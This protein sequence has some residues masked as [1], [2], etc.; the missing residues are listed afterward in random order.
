MPAQ[1]LN[2]KHF[3]QQKL[4]ELRHLVD[5]FSKHFHRRPSLA[6]IVIGDLTASMLYI[7]YKIAACHVLG[8]KSFKFVFAKDVSEAEIIDKIIELNNLNEVDGILV[9]LPLPAHINSALVMQTIAP[10]KDVDGFHPLNMGYLA[11]NLPGLR[12]CT[13]K[14]II[15]L[16]EQTGENLIDKHAVILGS[17]LIVGRPMALELIARRATVTICNSKTQKIQEQVAQADILIVAIGQYEY[18]QGNWCKPG[19]III[20]V[21]INKNA[22]GQLAG[23]VHFASASAIASWIT[24]VPGGVG[25]MTVASLMENTVLAYKINNGL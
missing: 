19:C 18:V 16:L 1:I 11:T 23:D 3:A 4:T 7:K 10:H 17:S 13:P 12:P 24:P 9:Q 21:G 15:Y 8:I 5:G 2:G 25:P 22:V 6:V 20:D 14:G